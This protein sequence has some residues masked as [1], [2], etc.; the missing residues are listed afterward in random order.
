M[1]PIQ[2][3]PRMLSNRK[4]EKRYD[5]LEVVQTNKNQNTFLL[6]IFKKKTSLQGVR[7]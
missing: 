3:R 1:K 7:L 6:L 4:K 2:S 5:S